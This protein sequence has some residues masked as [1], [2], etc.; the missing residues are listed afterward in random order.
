MKVAGDG[1]N[2]W[3]PA[4]EAGELDGVS[5]CWLSLVQ[6]QP[7]SAV[8]KWTSIWDFLSFFLPIGRWHL[9][10]WI[11]RCLPVHSHLYLLAILNGISQD[12]LVLLHSIHLAL[13]WSHVWMYYTQDAGFCIWTCQLLKLII[14]LEFI[15][16]LTH[17]L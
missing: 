4:T 16:H 6:V 12:L 8:G 9:S 2:G 15:K 7:A 1:T 10:E 5:C 3:L 11:H 17:S 14:W 13:S